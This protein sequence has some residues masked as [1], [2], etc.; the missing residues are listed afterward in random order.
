VANGIDTAVDR[1]QPAPQSLVD[2]AAA[3]PGGKQL[4]S[5]HHA[6]LPLRQFRED[7]IRG[8]RV[9]FAP[10]SVVNATL[11]LRWGI[12]ALVGHGSD[13]DRARRTGGALKVR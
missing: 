5:C 12:A 2:R 7:P 13:A 1:V 8:T 11:V 6:V 4:L 3:D 10:N 9:A